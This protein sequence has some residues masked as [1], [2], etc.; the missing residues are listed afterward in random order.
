M[1]K[2]HAFRSRDPVHFL[3][4]LVYA[5]LYKSSI[6]LPHLVAVLI[7]GKVSGVFVCELSWGADCMVGVDCL[8]E[9]VT[10]SRFVFLAVR[11]S[12]I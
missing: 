2:E 5:F 3:F 7:L 6:F 9:V 1:L 8:C 4:A 11:V 10:M 12:Q